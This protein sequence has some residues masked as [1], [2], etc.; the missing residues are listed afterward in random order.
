MEPAVKAAVSDGMLDDEM[1][2]DV[3]EMLSARISAHPQWF[4]RGRNEASVIDLGGRENR[5]DRVVMTGGK[6]IVID[7]KFGE[8]ESE[9]YIR[10]VERYIQLYRLMGYKNVSGV[11]WYVPADKV[12]E[13]E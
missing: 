11:V 4:V 12:V 8:E 1:G 6:T 10:Q 2:K 13:V 9:K 7:Y 5:P 3:L